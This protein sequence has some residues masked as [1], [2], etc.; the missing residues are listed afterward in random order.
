MI[1]TTPKKG[2]DAKILGADETSSNN[3]DQMAKQ[4]G[5]F[6]FILNTI[7]VDHDVAPYLD[8]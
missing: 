8:L 6:D 2:E 5:E 7:P 4:A 1:T 3:P